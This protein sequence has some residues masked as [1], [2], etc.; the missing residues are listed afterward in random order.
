MIFS[1]YESYVYI[2]GRYKL[3]LPVFGE[4]RKNVCGLLLLRRAT[5]AEEML[6]E[7]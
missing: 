6:R 2:S 3:N 4:N 7:D 5:T 1:F